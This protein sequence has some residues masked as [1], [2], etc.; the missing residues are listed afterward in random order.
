[1]SIFQH[2]NSAESRFSDDKNCVTCQTT[3]AEQRQSWSKFNVIRSGETSINGRLHFGEN[4][5]NDQVSKLGT[6]EGKE[7]EEFQP[8]V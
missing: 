2:P 5:F 3:G 6:A 4:Y 8:Q 7:P 1:M